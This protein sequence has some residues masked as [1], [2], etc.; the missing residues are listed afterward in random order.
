MKYN[1]DN[2]YFKSYDE[3]QGIMIDKKNLYVKPK[4]K[5]RSYLKSVISFNIAVT[6]ILGLFSCVNFF[7]LTIGLSALNFV[8][9]IVLLTNLICLYSFIRSYKLEKNKDHSGT[10]EINENGITDI[11]NVGIIVSMKWEQIEALILGRY[12]ATFTTNTHIFY[13]VNID[14]KDQIIKE[15]QKFNKNLLIIDKSQK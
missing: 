1:L 8:L 5:I 7:N 4:R 12:T 14:L 15:V 9:L 2:N 11:S 10:L 13:F 6:I 3:A